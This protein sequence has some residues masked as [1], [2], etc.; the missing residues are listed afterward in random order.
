M[1][2]KPQFVLDVEEATGLRCERVAE[3]SCIQE[4]HVI[5][6][7]GK[8]LFKIGGG[9]YGIGMVSMPDMYDL[10]KPVGVESA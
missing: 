2:E 7:T 8:P 1:D 10:V 5:S 3:L 9:D 6:P 4:W